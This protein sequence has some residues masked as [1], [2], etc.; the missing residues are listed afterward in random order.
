MPTDPLSKLFFESY[1]STNPETIVFLH[2]GGVSGWMWRQQA[3]SLQA[4]YHCLIPD[5]PGQ[6]KSSPFDSE[7]FTIERA[8]ARIALFVRSQAH[9]GRAHVVGLSEGAQVLVSLL[10][11]SPEVVDHAVISSALLR[12]L[13]PRWLVSRTLFDLSYRLFIAPWKSN[14][15]WIRLNMRYSTGIPDAYYQDF[16]RSFQE[17]TQ[18]SW[19]KLMLANL[20]F[21]MPEGLDRVKQPVL[22]IVGEKE[23][24]QMKQSA[25]DLVR[26]LPN[27]PGVVLSLGEKATLAQEHNWALT[28]P[29][30]FTDT[31]RAWVENR[32]LP[33]QLKPLSLPANLP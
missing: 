16:K 21:R 29:Q 10:S 28:A 23:H 30:L 31:I 4:D 26:A 9:S 1:G 20:S 5:L 22:V 25:K 2:G 14:D 13:A 32:P 27:A 7:P 24:K 18:A 33:A 11:Q 19:T 17:T 3:R 15:G 8:A 12:P 6:G